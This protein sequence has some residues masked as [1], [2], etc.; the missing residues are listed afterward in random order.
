MADG[1]WGRPGVRFRVSGA[2]KAGS[3]S[4]ES[5]EQVSGAGARGQK[6]GFQESGVGRAGV[7]CRVPGASRA[8]SGSQESE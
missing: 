5:E 3:R 4:Q 1:R 6:S 2:R 8:G 7:R